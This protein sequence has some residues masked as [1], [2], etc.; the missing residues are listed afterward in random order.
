MNITTRSA[1]LFALLASLVGCG[2]YQ[3]RGR[4]VEGPTPAVLVVSK[5][6]SRLNDTAV[7]GAAVQVTVDPQQMKPRTLDPVTTGD[8]GRFAV[9]IGDFGAGALE[10][11]VAI[12]SRANGFQASNAIVKLPGSDKRVLIIMSPGR[13]T[14]RDNDILRETMR[15]KEELES[16]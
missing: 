8:D 9:P 6:D 3:L 11:Q 2:S 1:L 10:Y 15:I 4:V 14:H 5:D 13:D 16:R 12:L 7:V